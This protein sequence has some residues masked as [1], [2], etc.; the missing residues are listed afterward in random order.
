MNAVV[1]ALVACYE[2]ATP[3]GVTSSAPVGLEDSTGR[4]ERVDGS[5]PPSVPCV[6]GEGISVEAVAATAGG[7]ATGGIGRG[8]E[9]NPELEA[10]GNLLKEIKERNR[11]LSALPLCDSPPQLVASEARVTAPPLP[12]DVT[13]HSELL[14]ATG[15]EVGNETAAMSKPRRLCEPPP[16]AL[17]LPR[18]V[19]LCAVAINPVGLVNLIREGWL[20][21]GHGSG[22]VKAGLGRHGGGLP[23]PTGFG[24]GQ[25]CAS[26]LLGKLLDLPAVGV[27]SGCAGEATACSTRGRYINDSTSGLIAAFRGTL[28]ARTTCVECERDRATREEFTELTLPPLLPQHP[29]PSPNRAADK[30]S[31]SVAAGA[32]DHPL[33]ERPTLKGL[34][35]EVLGSEILGGTSKVWCEACRQWTEAKRRVSIYSP[36]RL[37][38]LHVRPATGGQSVCPPPAVGGAI[39][40]RG[41]G[42]RK[43]RERDGGGSKDGDEV[44]ERVLSVKGVAR[45][46]FHV[47]KGEGAAASSR[48]RTSATTCT[49]GGMQEEARG[50]EDRTNKVGD[51]EDVRYELVGIILHVGQ[52]LGSGHYTFALRTSSSNRWVG[53]GSRQRPRHSSSA[54]GVGTDD[55]G[56]GPSPRETDAKSSESASASATEGVHGPAGEGGARK[57]LGVSARGS[58]GEGAVGKGVGVSTNE[59][60]FVLFDD[61]CVRWL[62]PEEC[63]VLRD[64][65]GR[66]GLGHAFLVFYARRP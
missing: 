42:T 6:G 12:E 64:G 32:N 5:G 53:Q 52:T 45:R 35:D 65:G 20:N 36:P 21:A 33:S 55:E 22:E 44:I 15:I 17:N 16:R 25:Q 59:E 18:G 47:T 9:N 48:N 57:G 27:T 23:D 63:E 62:T 30:A 56:Y 8:D 2:A 41:R 51:F 49:S 54:L 7:S 50:Q 24:S 14:G 28:C 31:G 34:V 26:E 10:L 3:G 37:L 38:A 43:R 58:A 60:A 1:Q 4:R 61:A 40:M 29:T 13:S 11:A 39:G 19:G 46:G 66:G